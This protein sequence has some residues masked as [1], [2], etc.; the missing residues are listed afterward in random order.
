ML[1]IVDHHHESPP[2]LPPVGTEPAF[3]HTGP[4]AFRSST[5]ALGSLLNGEGSI[6][7]NAKATGPCKHTLALHSTSL[8]R[9]HSNAEGAPCE[10]NTVGVSSGGDGCGAVT[11]VLSAKTMTT[12]RPDQLMDTQRG[13][14]ADV[15]SAAVLSSLEERQ[16]VG[17]GLGVFARRER[18]S[19][20][21][22]PGM[23]LPASTS[24]SRASG[25]TAEARDGVEGRR[26]R[27]MR[28]HYS[29]LYM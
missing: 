10:T 14:V 22:Q 26:W 7:G 13:G 1:A 28:W 29:H 9:T 18:K 19:A 12:P 3:P 15:G 5:S 23:Q 27:W 4:N 2:R 25:Q 11:G 8:Y 21:V 24:Q 17:D 16:L 6:A 20:P